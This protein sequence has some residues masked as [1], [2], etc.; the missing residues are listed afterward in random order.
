[1]EPLIQG[2]PDRAPLPQYETRPFSRRNRD[3]AADVSAEYWFSLS[4]EGVES[5]IYDNY[6]MRKSK[7]INFLNRAARM[8]P[9]RLSS[10]ICWINMALRS[11]F[12]AIN[13]YIE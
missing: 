11:F 3:Y 1:M 7:G 5:T 4:N 6:A 9:L 8:L 2:N 12:D 10:D 13:R